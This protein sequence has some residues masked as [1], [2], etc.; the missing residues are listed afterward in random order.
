[1]RDPA[2]ISDN[3]SQFLGCAKSISRYIRRRVKDREVAAEL[4]QDVSI[5]LLAHTDSAPSGQSFEHW[6]RGIAR[7]VLAHYF[8]TQR[9]QAALLN[10]AEP[11]GHT[12]LAQAPRDPEHT[13]ATREL[14]ARIFDNVDERS[15]RLMIERYLMG[16]SADEIAKQA[17]Q[18]PSSVRMKLMRVRGAVRSG[19][20]KADSWIDGGN[21]D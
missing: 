13:F 8:R 5:L 12:L 6:C 16:R 14:L 18:S 1:L 11:E 9:R 10:R 21:S 2:I 4:F 3:F 19:R 20:P 17:D 7:N 15:R